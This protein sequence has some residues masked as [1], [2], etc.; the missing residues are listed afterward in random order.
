[1]VDFTQRPIKRLDDAL[2]LDAIECQRPLGTGA[3]AFGAGWPQARDRE[4]LRFAGMATE[5]ESNLSSRPGGDVRSFGKGVTS[6]GVIALLAPFALALAA[7]LAVFLFTRPDTTGDEPHYLL[8][9]E[10]IAYDRDVVLTKD[11]ASPDRISRIFPSWPLDPHLHAADYTGSGELR[12]LRGVGLPALLAPAV[13]LG[14]VTGARLV[15]VLVAALLADQLYRLLRALGFR[16]RYRALAWAAA[17]FCLPLLV[18]SSQIY[19]ELP[20]ALLVVV[21]LRIMVE[22]VASPAA[23][24]LGSMASAALLWL[25]IRYLPLSLGV[26]LGLAY[27][28]FSK[29]RTNLEA[30]AAQ[31]LGRSQARARAT[32]S[33]FAGTAIKRWQTVTLPLV[34]PYAVGVSLLGVAY[35]R[36]YGSLD[37]RT[38]YAVFYENSFGSSGWRFWYEYALADLLDPVFG[39]IPYVPV[40]WLGLAALGCLIVRFGWP[41][42]IGVALAVGYELALASANLPIGRVLPARLLII[43]IPLIAI[44]LAV[45]IQHVRAARIVFLPLLGCSLVFAVGAVRDFEWLYPVVEKPRTFGVRSVA[46]AFPRP[47]P[48]VFATSFTSPPLPQFYPHTGE[49]KGNKVV[50]N[51]G[52]HTP[53]FA[54]WGPNIGLKS[55]SYQATFPLAVTGARRDEPVAT[56]DVVG[57]PEATILAQ[58]TVIAAELAPPLPPRVSLSFTTPGSFLIQPRVY[59]HG[60][61]TLTVDPVEVRADPGTPSPAQFRDWPLAFLWVAGTILVGGVFVQTMRRGPAAW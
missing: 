9:A 50:A 49:V 26:F 42:A 43:V 46:T 11:Y 32:L 12:S 15:M 5:V 18:F 52:R 55:G 3:A 17:V 48:D 24:A 47:R 61:G 14:G 31:R 54:L 45:A 39:W 16:R 60:H 59:Y 4:V 35:Q 21:A 44:P 6:S 7:Y 41:A 58:K 56:I 38:P 20:A 22:R 25:H 8:V 40:H 28:A 34:V 19:P 29:E 23:L 57:L 27:A 10:S 33:R 37:P 51:A 1:V 53:G 36:W 2:S 13:V 30:P